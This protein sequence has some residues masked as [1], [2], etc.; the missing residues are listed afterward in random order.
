MRLPVTLS[1]MNGLS[2][3]SL[4]EELLVKMRRVGFSTLNPALVSSDK[5]VLEFAE[6]P[7]TVGKFFEILDIADRKT[8]SS[9][10]RPMPFDAAVGT[11][12]HTPKTFHCH[13]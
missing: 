5:I 4:D 7:R 3:I 13:S 11:P 12:N 10:R 2:Y 1:A 8:I 9:R 6:R